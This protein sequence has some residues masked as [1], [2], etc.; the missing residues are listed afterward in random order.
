M[1]PEHR[2]RES[3]RRAGDLN[4]G[5]Y[6]LTAAANGTLYVGG[7]FSNVANIAAADHIASYDGDWHALGLGVPDYVRSLASS[8]NDV[9]VGTDSVNIGG[10]QQADHVA[11]WNG[12]AWSALGANTAG[13]DGWLPAGAFIYA[14]AAS[15]SHVVA[16]GSFENANGVA[17]ADT[18]ASFDGTSGARSARTAEA[19]VR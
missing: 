17:T 9:Y 6:A 13:T 15:G 7:Q 2:C 19:T 14:L 5:V 8:G 4:G 16:A 1:R 10:I 3:S 18:V 11:R 12:S